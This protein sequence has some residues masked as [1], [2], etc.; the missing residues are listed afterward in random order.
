MAMEEELL[1]ETFIP[2]SKTTEGAVHISGSTIFNKLQEQT[3]QTLNTKRF[4]TALHSQGFVSVS[5]WVGSL[6][7]SRYGYWVKEIIKNTTN[8]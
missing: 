3:K 7:Q 4:T 1:S 5:N 6:N 8:E 2:A